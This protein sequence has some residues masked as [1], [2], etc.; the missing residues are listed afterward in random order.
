[1][2]TR[3]TVITT[4]VMRTMWNH[5]AVMVVLL[6]PLDRDNAF[7]STACISLPD[8]NEDCCKH[9][10]IDEDNSRMCCCLMIYGEDPRLVRW[11][12]VKRYVGDSF[13]ERDVKE[14]STVMDCTVSTTRM[15]RAVLEG[16]SAS[17][18]T[19]RIPG[20]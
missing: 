10:R 7:F 17:R 8:G 20:W 1:M 9:H 14:V 11:H 18:F 5:I 16:A 3:T 6:K 2:A 19:A 13:A 15:M 12:L 4:G